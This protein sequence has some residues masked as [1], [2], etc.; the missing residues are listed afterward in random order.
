MAKCH[1]NTRETGEYREPRL[2]SG[3]WEQKQLELVT[4]RNIYTIT[5]AFLEAECRLIS[6][7]KT[8]GVQS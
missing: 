8:L 7:I 2:R 3:Y 4:G 5:D 6:D 1:S